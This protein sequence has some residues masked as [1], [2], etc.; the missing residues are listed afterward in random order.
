MSS[1]DLTKLR[2]GILQNSSVQTSLFSPGR[3][4][5][6]GDQ[7]KPMTRTFHFFV[8]LVL[9]FIASWTFSQSADRMDI[10]EQ[11]WWAFWQQFTT[12]INKKDH[13]ALL[14]M[15]PSDFFDGG[16]GLTPKQ[17]AAIYRQKR[18]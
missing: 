12:A 3:A 6:T 8:M 2:T 5:K 1:Q 9:L 7:S 15:M 18:P 11:S 17:L 10:A 13:A 4:D 16:G 14:R